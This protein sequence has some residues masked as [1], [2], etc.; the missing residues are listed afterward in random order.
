[1]ENPKTVKGF[2]SLLLQVADLDPSSCKDFDDL[3]ESEQHE[4]WGILTALQNEFGYEPV[5][6]L[7]KKHG[8]KWGKEEFEE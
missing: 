3:S 6:E 2:L 1:M 8:L 7:L 4:L 5:P